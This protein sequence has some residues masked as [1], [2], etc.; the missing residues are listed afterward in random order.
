MLKQPMVS[1]SHTLYLHAYIVFTCIQDGPY[2]RYCFHCRPL[3]Q[4]RGGAA[5]RSGSNTFLGASNRKA[6]T[7]VLQVSGLVD[8]VRERACT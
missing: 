3:A 6:R 8:Q 5:A 2:L 1:P 4:A 7:I